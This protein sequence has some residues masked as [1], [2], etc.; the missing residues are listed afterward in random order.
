MKD[1]RARW[2]CTVGILDLLP[3]GE[4]HNG[5][6]RS[7]WGQIRFFDNQEL[8]YGCSRARILSC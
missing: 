2:V 6:I 5:C 3:E 1:L 4:G 7:G 8:L